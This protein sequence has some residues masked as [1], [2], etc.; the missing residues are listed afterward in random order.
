[1]LATLIIAG[2]LGASDPHPPTAALDQPN[3]S[4]QGMAHPSYGPGHDEGARRLCLIE[5][6]SGRTI[7]RRT[8]AWRDLN[9]R[10]ERAQSK[11]RQR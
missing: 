7:C 8:D 6:S 4:S 2:L 10:L 5:R 1:M 3:S 11:K 9:R